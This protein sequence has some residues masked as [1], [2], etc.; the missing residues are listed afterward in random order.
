MIGKLRPV[1]KDLYYNDTEKGGGTNID[2]IVMIKSLFL[3]AIYNISNEALESELHDRLLF[4][5]FFN[6]PEIIPDAKTIWHFRELLSKTGKDKT[7]WIDNK[8]NSNS[9]SDKWF[10]EYLGVFFYFTVQLQEEIY[11]ED[12]IDVSILEVIYKVINNKSKLKKN[13]LK[14]FLRLKGC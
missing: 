1:L 10:W 3:Q 9:L 11:R 14:R 4:R 2:E 7:I 8:T 6:Y 13:I 5:N 12:D